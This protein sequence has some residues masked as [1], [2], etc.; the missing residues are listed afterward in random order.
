MKL[1]ICSILDQTAQAFFQPMYFN[2]KGTAIRSFSDAV[3]SGSGEI[4]RH[5]DQYTLYQIGE[6]D[7]STGL[8]TVVDHVSLGNG[9]QYKT[10]DFNEDKVDMLLKEIQSL[11]TRG[12]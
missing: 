1:L 5:P 3:N 6:F 9:A 11:K 8:I 2:N 4:S 12:N 10:T 7:D